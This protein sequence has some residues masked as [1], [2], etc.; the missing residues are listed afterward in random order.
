MGGCRVEAGSAGVCRGRN[1]SVVPSRDPISTVYSRSKHLPP[2]PYIGIYN[3]IIAVQHSVP[4]MF[5]LTIEPLRDL[6]CRYYK[7][8]EEMLKSKPKKAPRYSSLLDLNI[9]IN[10]LNGF[11]LQNS[12]N[13]SLYQ[14]QIEANV[15]V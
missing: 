11:V 10:G 5:T 13:S 9:I 7:I 2:I 3:I 14:V 15:S 4:G 1:F 8:Y 12:W 6:F